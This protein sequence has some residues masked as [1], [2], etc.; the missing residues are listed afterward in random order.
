M[1][2]TMHPTTAELVEEI[3]GAAFAGVLGFLLVQS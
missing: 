2:T 3:L 1:L